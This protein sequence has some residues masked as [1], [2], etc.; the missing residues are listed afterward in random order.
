V[1]DHD[2]I[3]GV[4]AG[5]LEDQPLRATAVARA[6]CVGS[7][8]A[9][10][11]AEMRVANALASMVGAVPRVVGDHFL[12]VAGVVVGDGCRIYTRDPAVV[13]VGLALHALRGVVVRI[14]GLFS[15]AAS[16]KER[17][18]GELHLHLARSWEKK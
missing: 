15:D 10:G 5:K 2:L 16:E 6:W 9:H 11:V 13:L 1:I 7:P 8:D 3:D 14:D 17:E 18:D 12:A 4:A